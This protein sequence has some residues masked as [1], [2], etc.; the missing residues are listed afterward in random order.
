MVGRNG[1]AN[2]RDPGPHVARARVTARW[3]PSTG[4][5]GRGRTHRGRQ[6]VGIAVVAVAALAALAG[7]TA[8]RLGRVSRA[9]SAATA[10][11]RR[12]DPDLRAGNVAGIERDLQTAE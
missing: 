9:L 4:S 10:T 7:V 5:Q 11:L 3:R 2:R 6:L 1:R 8:W 12:V